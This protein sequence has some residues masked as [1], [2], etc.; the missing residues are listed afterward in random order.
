MDLMTMN[1]GRSRPS[2]LPSRGEIWIFDPEPVLGREQG[3]VRPGLIASTD[4]LNHSDRGMVVI[5]PMTRVRRPPEYFPLHVAVSAESSGLSYESYVMCEQ[6]RAI[7]ID[8][9]YGRRL[10]GAV[11]ITTMKEIDA[12]LRLL[13]DL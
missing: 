12:R 3:K 10:R 7:S 8:R 1:N 9:L 2:R 13:L 5:I 11:D 4:N 6:I